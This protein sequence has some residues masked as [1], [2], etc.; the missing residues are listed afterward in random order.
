MQVYSSHE[1]L[2]LPDALNVHLKVFSSWRQK[3]ETL[4]GF[5]SFVKDYL[6]PWL[7]AKCCTQFKDDIEARFKKFVEMILASCISF[8][9]NQ[10]WS[11]QHT[12]VSG[13][14]Q[15]LTT[16]S[17]LLLLY[18]FDQQLQQ[19]QNFRKKSNASH[20]ETIQTPDWHRDS[21]SFFFL[22]FAKRKTIWV[23]FLQLKG[24]YRTHCASWICDHSKFD[25]THAFFLTRRLAK[26]CFQYVKRKNA[27]FRGTGWVIVIDDDPIVQK[28]KK[29]MITH[30]YHLA[31]ENSLW[32]NWN[33]L[34]EA[35]IFWQYNF[36]QTLFSHFTWAQQNW[37]QFWPQNRSLTQFFHSE[38]FYLPL[39]HCFDR[40]LVV[41][42]CL[43]TFLPG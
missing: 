6:E 42:I 11:L 24:I 16:S 4:M 34:C 8:W 13:E 36:P 30:W 21:F 33:F 3:F 1:R 29:R 38:G 19:L 23:I 7:T 27:S 39:W 20:C 43:L 10:V 25:L 28:G 31:C 41:N 9:S 5:M 37:C 40:F 15:K 14:K 17:V 18:D 22:V 26:P 35:K 12:N 2:Q 32:R